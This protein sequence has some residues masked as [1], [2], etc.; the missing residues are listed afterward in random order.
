MEKEA[1]IEELLSKLIDYEE[2][3]KEKDLIMTKLTEMQE[4]LENKEK[5]NE[6]TQRNLEEEIDKQVQKRLDEHLKKKKEIDE[7]LQEELQKADEKLMV[8]EEKI[9]I[10]EKKARLN[11]DFYKQQVNS[12]SKQLEDI[13]EKSSFD[14][15][16]VNSLENGY[17]KQISAL[18]KQLL[19]A[20]QKQV[21]I[22]QSKEIETIQWKKEAIS[23][24]SDN[25]RIAEIRQTLKVY[26]EELKKEIAL[27][28]QLL[29]DLHRD[30]QDKVVEMKEKYDLEK[31]AL[32]IKNQK[33]KND[34]DILGRGRGTGV[35]LKPLLN[36]LNALNMNLDEK[37]P[38][39]EDFKNT[40]LD[41]GKSED[42][43]DNEDLKKE[44]ELMRRVSSKKLLL[45]QES[46]S[47]FRRKSLL[48]LDAMMNNYK[49]ELEG[50]REEIIRLKEEEE[51]NKE[52]IKGLEEEVRMERE[53]RKGIEGDLEGK[54]EDLKCLEEKIEGYKTLE[55]ELGC[56]N[57][58]IKGL[59][60]ELIDKEGLLK[61]LEVELGCNKEQIKVFVKE[62]DLEK[63]QL[64]ALEVE[65]DSRKELTKNLTH[66]VNSLTDE[67]NSNKGELTS[68]NEELNSNKAQ[69]QKLLS[70]KHS[71]E[72]QAKALSKEIDSYKAEIHCLQTQLPKITELEV[73]KEKNKALEL[74]NARQT[75]LITDNMEKIEGLEE[76]SKII[77]SKLESLEGNMIGNK[78]NVGKIINGV[79][80]FEVEDKGVIEEKLI[81]VKTRY[82]YLL[83]ILAYNIEIILDL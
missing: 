2:S 77:A 18:Q 74:Q 78:G 55:E 22:I 3:S 44:I 50:L 33:L 37:S 24:E 66:E 49:N 12:Y 26:I 15:A 32:E 72:E 11:E 60:E 5:E 45:R 25:K 63:A 38:I 82:I 81:V 16:E 67:L 30:Y 4:L 68:L 23:K 56:V 17:K 42:E 8:L 83:M 46:M 70:I 75:A 64:N 61:G 59:E 36:E 40:S 71:D 76:D 73:L 62:L 35:V 14:T 52:L 13:E 39:F 53:K 58:K 48:E 43:E 10:T 57:E 79:K 19:E 54:K 65:L 21:D 47:N 69:I 1:Q 51:K 28:D 9:E 34:G 31:N 27:K 6:L 20:E 7:Q 80:D 29:E 41:T